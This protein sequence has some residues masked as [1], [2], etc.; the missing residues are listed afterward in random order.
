LVQEQQ[1]AGQYSVQWNAE[2]LPSGIY[3]YRLVAGE[4]VAIKKLILMK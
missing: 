4:L 2:N 1:A 3:V